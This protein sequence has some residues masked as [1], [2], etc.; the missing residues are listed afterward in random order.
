MNAIST[1]TAGIVAPTRT[2]KGACLMPRLAVSG[3]AV[4][5]DLDRLGELARLLQVRALGEVPED[6][7]EVVVAGGIRRSRAG[8]R[9]RLV[10]FLRDF[11]RDLVRGLERQVVRL[12]A[13]RRGRARGV[14]VDRQ[15]QVRLLVVG[16]R[17]PVVERDQDVGVA[18]QH[19]A[20]QEDLRQRRRRASSRSGASPPSPGGRPARSRRS[21]CRRARGRRRSSAAERPA[22]RARPARRERAAA[23]AL[24]PTSMTM[25]SG[26]VSGYARAVR[27]GSRNSIVAVS[28]E[29]RTA[30]TSGSSNFFSGQGGS[31]FVSA[32][33]TWKPRLGQHGRAS[34]RPP[35]AA[36][37]PGSSARRGRRRPRSRAG[38]ARRPSASRRAWPR[39]RCR[40]RRPAER[41]P[42]RRNRPG[43]RARRRRRAPA[44]RSGR[45]AGPRGPAPCR[46]RARIW[47]P[48]PVSVRTPVAGV[49][50]DG[51]AERP[52]GVGDDEFL[53][54][55]RADR[56]RFALPEEHRVVLRAG[57]EDGG[58]KKDEGRDG[59]NAA[60]VSRPEVEVCLDARALGRKG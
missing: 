37:R 13:L 26:E 11:L 10:F 31:T 8:R 29:K 16:D 41:G 46:G 52:R 19:R 17:G 40:P 43:R 60:A 5:L 2:R 53:A 50:G 32:N 20:A 54:P 42:S 56:M 21:R 59:G 18:R 4:Q 9:A 24:R 39:R 57:R 44:A 22:A 30:A 36:A 1:R 15:E 33:R 14:G 12:R 58:E 3:D 7:V 51:V 49:R 25:R 27:F 23:A 28:P 35:R 38:A 45:C 6:E 48:W 34:S 55:D 47:W